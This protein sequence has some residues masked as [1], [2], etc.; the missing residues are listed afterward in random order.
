MDA[1]R[2]G[3]RGVATRRSPPP[4]LRSGRRRL[5]HGPPGRPT[6]GAHRGAHRP[7]GRPRDGSASSTSPTMR[8]VRRACSPRRQAWLD[9]QGAIVDDRPGE[10]DARRGVR[11][12]GPRRR[13]LRRHRTGV[14]AGLVRPPTP[15]GEADAG[16]G[17]ALLSHPDDRRRCDR[18]CDPGPRTRRWAGGAT[19]RRELRRPSPRARRHRGGTG[20][21]GHPR[22]GLAPISVVGGPPG[23]G[24]GLRHRGV[25]A[26]RRANR[27]TW[28][29]ELQRAAGRAGYADLVAPWAPKGVRPETSHQVFRRSW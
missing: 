26:V 9:E 18:C 1:G 8:D 2:T 4:V 7:S 17:A 16:R 5:P 28:C 29:P 11:R 19:A 14:A 10:L 13:A 23:P 20:R 15:P 27:P 22:P 24:P 12:P 3:L 21:L 6:G 25:R